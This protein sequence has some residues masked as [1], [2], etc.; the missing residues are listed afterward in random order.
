MVMMG[1]GMGC[2][3][4]PATESIL[5]VLPPSSRVASLTA[6][7]TPARAGGTL[8]VAV[9]GS[10]FSS[11][12]AAHLADSALARLPGGALATAQDSVGA[13][14]SIA[15]QSAELQNAVRDSFMSGLS[16]ASLVIGVL[17]LVAAAVAV[18]VLPGRQPAEL[19][20]DTE[21]PVPVTV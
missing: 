6:D 5:L 21:Q 13:A 8:G 15:A 11:V 4:T 16:V 2:I 7:P 3:S 10:I 12:Y 18:R 20:D 9:V 1:L 14:Q 17:C 19:V